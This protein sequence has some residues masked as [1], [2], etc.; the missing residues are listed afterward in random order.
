VA[1]LAPARSAWRVAVSG[2]TSSASARTG[3]WCL[4]D[5][6]VPCGQSARPGRDAQSAKD[7]DEPAVAAM[8][9]GELPGKRPGEG[10]VSGGGY[11]AAVAQVV[12]E[13][14]GDGLGNVEPR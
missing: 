8:F 5:E 13:Q 6:L 2:E 12:P 9:V 1:Q 14:G 3:G 7:D 11:V 4:A 10:R